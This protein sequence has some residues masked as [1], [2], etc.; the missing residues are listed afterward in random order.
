MIFWWSLCG[1]RVAWN[2]TLHGFAQSCLV[3]V[4]CVFS[5]VWFIWIKWLSK[6]IHNVVTIVIIIIVSHLNYSFVVV[7]ALGII[8]PEEWSILKE[9]PEP[10]KA[11]ATL[12]AIATYTVDGEKQQHTFIYCTDRTSYYVGSAP[13][14]GPGKYICGMGNTFVMA[15]THDHLGLD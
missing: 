5:M 12:A 10:I 2:S 7:A 15:F 8:N 3:W 13:Q 1:F 14:F 11:K 9:L 4:K 6:L